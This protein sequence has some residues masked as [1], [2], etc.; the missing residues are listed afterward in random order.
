MI[1]SGD[2]YEDDLK[3]LAEHSSNKDI[4]VFIE[5]FIAEVEESQSAELC[6]MQ[7][8]AD[9]VNP[10]FNVRAINHLQKK[11]YNLY[12]LRP[13]GSNK[14]NRFRIIYAY[15]NEYDD[16]YLLAVVEKLSENQK[17]ITVHDRIY[18]Y[19]EAHAI[20]ERVCDEYDEL[21]IP[22]LH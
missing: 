11:G 21:N 3:Y 17:G 4:K 10:F 1:Y 2:Y 8:K 5:A 20:I 18:N 6:L 13:L 22:K 19:E 12:R 16:F 14:I 15:D 7:W 9:C